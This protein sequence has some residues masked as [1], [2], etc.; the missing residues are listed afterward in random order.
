MNDSAKGPPS[1]V[2]LIRHAEKP[3][4]SKGHAVSDD[5]TTDPDLAPAGY[6]RAGAYA[7]YFDPALSGK[8]YPA[9][10]H[11]F[12]TK[13]S[14]KSNRPVLTVTPLSKALG[15]TIHDQY[16]NKPDD[17]AKLGAGPAGRVVRRADDPRL[18]APRHAAR[19]RQ[20]ARISQRAVDSGNVVRRRLAARVRRGLDDAGLHAGHREPDV[21]RRGVAGDARHGRDGGRAGRQLTLEEALAVAAA[22]GVDVAGARAEPLAGG[23]SNELV[24]VDARSG[25]Y[26]VRRYGR[27]HVT[28]AA[29]AFEHAVTAHAAARLPEVVAPLRDADG[30]TVR[31]APDG[32]L[33]AVYPYVAGTSGRRDPATGQA[34]ARVLARFH[35]SMHDVHVA[36]GMRSARFLGMLP[37][38]RERFTRLAHDPQLARRLDWAALVTAVTGATARVAPRAG[39]LPHV[40]VHGDPNPGNV[41]VDAGG[42]VRGLIDFD[43]A[44]ETER[45]YDLGTLLDEFARAGDDAPL[46]LGPA[47]AAGRRLCRG[48]AARARRTGARARS[49][50]P[51]RRDPGLVRRHPARRARPGR[52]RRRAALC[53]PGGRDRRPPGRDPRGARWLGLQTRCSGHCWWAV[54]CS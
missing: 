12:A 22:F 16:D 35:R 17:I 33:V 21:R 30:A 13:A 50:A 27:L 34:A 24:R 28:R 9:I 14:S 4:E 32:G 44:H 31:T 54:C 18:L 2:I 15:K 20:G 29:I 37:W 25:S 1:L 42:A 38:L 45:V 11:I 43:F 7:A 3:G 40:I 49:D 46:E 26:A 8:L 39:G 52:R 53:R 6:Y 23:Y 10:D 36:G 41:I 5:D 47:A 48:S 51:P 19:R